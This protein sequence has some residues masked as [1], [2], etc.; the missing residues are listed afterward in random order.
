MVDMMVADHVYS[1]GGIEIQTPVIIGF[2]ENAQITECI[3]SP[4]LIENTSYISFAAS[5]SDAFI[6][7]I[8]LFADIFYTILSEWCC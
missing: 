3:S 8:P 7:L 1:E 5:T 2:Q 4:A 6:E